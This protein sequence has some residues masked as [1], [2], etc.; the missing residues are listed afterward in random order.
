[1]T[2]QA[3]GDPGGVVGDCAV[4]S[5][6]TGDGPE[7]VGATLQN[8]AENAGVG[9]FKIQPGKPQQNAYVERYDRTVRTEWLGQYHLNN[10]EEVQDHATRWLWTYNN[11]RPNMGVG[12]VT[13][14][15]KLS[16]A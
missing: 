13:T 3:A 8:W 5:R 1:M 9:L 15:Q 14:V 6:T 12:G 4:G 2:R 11:E 7:Y 10:F 16:A